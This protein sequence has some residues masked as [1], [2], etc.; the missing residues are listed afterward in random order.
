MKEHVKLSDKTFELEIVRKRNI[1]HIYLKIIDSHKLQIRTNIWLPKE[2]IIDFVEK[3][4]A[5]ILKNHQN[6]AK[7]TINDDEMLYLGKSY[8]KESLLRPQE[9]IE[10]FY[11]KEAIE[12]ITPM[13]YSFAGQMGLYPTQIKF[14][15]N[16]RRWGSC[17][18]RNSINLNTNLIKHDIKFIEYVVV[19]ELAHIKHKHH[20]KEF[21]DLVEKYLPDYKEREKLYLL[22][23]NDL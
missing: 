11:R 13:V 6:I 23:V 15:K 19:H 4:S 9:S 14:R 18:Y 2:D 1:K 10:K 21:W 7:N 17:S 8:Q 22:S 20:K 3:K 12:K 5:W 16:K